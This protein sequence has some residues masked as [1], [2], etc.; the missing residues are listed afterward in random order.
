MKKSW[1]LLFSVINKSPNKSDQVQSLL[2]D[3][4][5]VQDPAEIANKFNYFFTNV[6]SNIV[7]EIPPFEISAEPDPEPDPADTP[8]FSFQQDPVTITEVA[9]ALLSLEP[10]KT[11]DVNGLSVFFLSKFARTIALPLHHVISKS[12]QAGIVPAQLK[13]AKVLPGSSNF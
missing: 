13:I 12:F 6:A 11:N 5:T 4:I 9:D 2:V 8:I 3:G 7:N 10:K 1:Q